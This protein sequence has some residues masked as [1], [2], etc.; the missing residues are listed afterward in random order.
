[1]VVKSEGKGGP[2][3]TKKLGSK[4][5]YTSFKPGRFAVAPGQIRVRPLSLDPA[6]VHGSTGPEEPPHQHEDD[7]CGWH[8]EV[9][10]AQ[11]TV[12]DQDQESMV[13]DQLHS[14]DSVQEVDHVDPQPD[15]VEDND[16]AHEDQL[17]FNPLAIVP[18]QQPIIQPVNLMIGSVRVVYG[19]PLPLL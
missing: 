3:P 7:G 14:S 15:N 6:A 5:G 11:P 2:S 1:M 10:V 16:E 12:P 4:K 17:Q 13:I 19:R 18:Y 8:A 9:S